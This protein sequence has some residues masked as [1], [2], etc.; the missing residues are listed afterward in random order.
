MRRSVKVGEI[1][2]ATAASGKARR[3]PT[4]THSRSRTESSAI[5]STRATER[6]EHLMSEE[7]FAVDGTLIQSY[8]SM[9]SVRPIGTKHRTSVTERRM[10][11]PVIRR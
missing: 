6:V 11:I 10:T 7:N 5:A 8:T 4:R 9:K 2:R 3:L 1:G